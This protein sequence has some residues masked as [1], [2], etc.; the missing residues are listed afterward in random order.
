MIVRDEAQTLRRCL[1]SVRGVVREI[2]IADTGSKDETPQ[3]AREYGAQVVEIPW[4]DDFAKARN[5]ALAPLNCDWVLSLDAD[6]MLDP[7]AGA[8]IG[9][10]TAGRTVAAY[11]VTIRN[12]MRSLDDCIWD[13]PAIP[14]NWMVRSSSASSAR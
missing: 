7:S 1:E 3:I 12:Y 9:A 4:E 5:R 13:R 6:E 11:Q 8:A 14:N 2:V 10:L